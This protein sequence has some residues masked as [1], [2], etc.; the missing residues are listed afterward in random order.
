MR[1]IRDLTYLKR[2]RSALALDLFL[3]GGP[4]R[5]AVVFAHGGGFFKGQ[6]QGADVDRLAALL[7]GRGFA[8]ASL[9]TRLGTTISEFPALQQDAIRT[10]AARS[11]KAGLTLAPRLYGPAFE[12]ARQDLAA[13]IAWLRSHATTYDITSD[14]VGIVGV[15]AG[16][17]AGLSLAY[18]PRNLPTEARPDAVLA[19]SA[20]MVQPWR[21]HAGGPPC[22]L[23]NSAVDRIVP[24]ENPRLTLHRA[25]TTGAP[26]TGLTC[27]R[28]G[29]NPPFQALLEDRHTDGTPYA[30]H[31]TNLFTAM[32]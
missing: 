12:A 22:L 23:L 2:P 16:G 13:G 1:E 9:S 17:I 25:R 27:A 8:M 18:P 20:C 29:H 11:R 5:A 19:I 26:V 15:S 28:N 21:L 31:M 6:R 4:A 30:N 3:P 24:P 14:K 32:L 10:H 7:T